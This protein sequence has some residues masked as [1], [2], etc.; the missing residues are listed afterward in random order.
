VGPGSV[1]LNLNAPDPS[2]TSF[3]VQ[4]VDAAGAPVGAPRV[5]SPEETAAR[6]VTIT[7]LTGDVP[8]FFTVTATNAN[9]SSDP[10]PKVGPLT[11]QGGVVANAGPDQSIARKTTTQT[12]NLTAEG[13]STGG[14]YK[15]VQ[16]SPG[17]TTPMPSTDPDFVALTGATTA[18][19]SF[20]LRLFKF[21]MTN[22][23]LTFQLTVTTAAGTKTDEVNVTPI[24]DQVAIG[25]AKWK[26]GD[27]R[28]TGTSSVVGGTITVHKGTLSGVP[29][30]QAAVTAAAPPAVGGVF[31]ARSKATTAPFNTNPGT[32]W[33]E[34]TLGGAAG[35]F[36]VSG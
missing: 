22:K 7:G 6:S 1:T 34:S 21:P 14:T 23:P 24:P 20:Q 16:L 30:G 4:A 10:S 27:F 5:T 35:P 29:L 2:I 8:L 32:V 9:G 11:P 26:L 31:D 19:P 25:T 17:T 33:I 28:V 36:T 12:V 15:W 3:S 18:T 13:S